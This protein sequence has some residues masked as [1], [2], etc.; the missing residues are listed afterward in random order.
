MAQGRRSPK[1]PFFFL[2]EFKKERD[3]SNDPLGQLMVA[4]VAAQ[5][6]NHDDNPVYGAY[7]IGRNWYFAVLRGIEYSVSLGHNV[8][9]D[10]I[11]DV[12]CILKKTKNIIETLIQNKA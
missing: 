1:Y 4:M 5:Q 8:S 7:V 10:E 3:T 12:F 2:N 9:K 11:N 6:I